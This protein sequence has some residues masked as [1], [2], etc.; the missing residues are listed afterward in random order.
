MTLQQVY[1]EL[2]GQFADGSTRGLVHSLT[3]FFKSQK[4][5]TIF[6]H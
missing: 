4:D 1:A 5:Y 3:I 6:L 2:T